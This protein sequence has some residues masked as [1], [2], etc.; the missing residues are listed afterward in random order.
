MDDNTKHGFGVSSGV[1]CN[2]MRVR[3]PAASKRRWMVVFTVIPTI[4]N[5]GSRVPRRRVS[6]VY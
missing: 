6:Q 5:P 4:S 3:Q 1:A 2:T